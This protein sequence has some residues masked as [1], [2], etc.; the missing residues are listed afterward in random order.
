MFVYDFESRKRTT[1][2][3]ITAR[4]AKRATDTIVGKGEDA[5]K[6]VASLRK[7]C[8]AAQRCAYRQ[9]SPT[10]PLSASD[11]AILTH[12]KG[13]FLGVLLANRLGVD[14]H[15]LVHDVCVVEKERGKGVATDMFRTL[16]HIL[17]PLSTFELTVARPQEGGHP[18]A[19]R[20]LRERELPLKR[21]YER[22]GFEEMS[23]TS[24]YRV[25][26]RRRK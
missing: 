13:S 25:F 9:S 10:D 22:L 3:K 26:V 15:Y 18:L 16:F 19:N 23:V 1:G 24:E 7:D 8:F 5:C 20:V 21:M 4:L 14:G 17:S 12:E 6:N 11:V 2:V